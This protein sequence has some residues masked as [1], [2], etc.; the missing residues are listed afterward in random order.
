MK[1]PE[2]MYKLKHLWSNLR[3]SF[4]FLPA[5]IVAFCTALAVG[6]IEVDSSGSQDWMADWPR[7]FGA[8]A[9]GARGMLAT[10]AGSMTTV[11]GVTFSM[12]LVALTLASSQYTYL[13]HTLAADPY[14]QMGARISVVRGS[15]FD[16]TRQEGP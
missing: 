12:T 14:Q 8:G 7:L 16:P 3:E 13:E 11:V 6:L 4:W 9:A 5:L 15:P 2:T 1:G 10:I